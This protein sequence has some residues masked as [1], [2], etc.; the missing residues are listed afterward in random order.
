[1]RIVSSSKV[2]FKFDRLAILFLIAFGWTCCVD[3]AIVGLDGGHSDWR[4][5]R[6]GRK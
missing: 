1:M 4:G 6:F 3:D 2:R 5:G